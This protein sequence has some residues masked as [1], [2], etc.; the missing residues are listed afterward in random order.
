MR[1]V[2]KIIAGVMVV[3]GLV[4]AIGTAGASD[5]G[6]VSLGRVVTQLCISGG[7]CGVGCL[8]Y[9]VIEMEGNKND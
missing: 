8:I 4:L 9:R 1:K 3:A 2:C 7:L 6:Y 5:A